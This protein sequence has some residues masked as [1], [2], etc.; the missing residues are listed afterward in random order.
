MSNKIKKIV[1]PT[2]FSELGDFA[3][4][5]ASFIAKQTGASIDVV[6]I[7][8]GPSGALYS[9]EG[10]LIN[11]EGNDY[12]EWYN[13]LKAA[14]EKMASWVKDKSYIN[15]TSCSIGNVNSSILRYATANDMDLIVMGT[16]GLYS[17]GLW[18]QPSHAEFISNHSPVP[19]LT[20]KCDRTNINLKEI[21]LVSDF[22][23]AN[24]MDLSILKS[25]Q[26]VF[27]SKLLL[28][29][30]KKNNAVRSNSK[31]VSD[32]TA[33]AEVN[34]ITNYEA[35]IYEDDNVEA[36][37]GKFAAERDVDL[38]SLGTHQKKGFSKL[39]RVGISDDVINHLFH[40]V[41]TFPIL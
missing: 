3:Y 41:L 11:D 18:S 28:L 23:E 34:D 5:L 22:L 36:G 7:I 35:C 10:N 33:F 29:K 19:V 16:D 39:F 17:T 9:K 12:S 37:I 2:D 15:D 20:L 27:D 26:S 24:L 30:V 25:L 1:L 38:I 40:P 8:P 31:I 13:S 6:S 32:I 4:S 14:E 21:I